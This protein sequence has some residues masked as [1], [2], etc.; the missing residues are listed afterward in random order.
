MICLV[1]QIHFDILVATQIYRRS[2]EFRSAVVM[3]SIRMSGRWQQHRKR[4]M[5]NLWR[6]HATPWKP[7]R[8]PHEGRRPRQLGSLEGVD[9]GCEPRQLARDGVLVED[10]LGRRPMQFGLGEL[11]RRLGRRPVAGFD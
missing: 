6:P 5:T 2:A 9:P 1:N 7:S 8:T 11:Q 4:K 3:N 10:A